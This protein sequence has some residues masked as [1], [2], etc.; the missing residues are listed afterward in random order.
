MLVPLRTM[1]RSPVASTNASILALSY[2]G[3]CQG[4][5]SEKHLGTKSLIR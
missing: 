1:R 5:D 3:A 2:I 4:S